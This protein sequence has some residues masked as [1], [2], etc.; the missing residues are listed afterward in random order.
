MDNEIKNSLQ[1]IKFN[2]YK[3]DLPL[4]NI[5]SSGK[6]V[7]F[8][9]TNLF[10]QMMVDLFNSSPTH[11]SIIKRMTQL[12]A[13][14]GIVYGEN[15]KL[16]KWIQDAFGNVNDWIENVGQDFLIHNAIG[17]QVIWSND[18]KWISKVKHLDASKIRVSHNDENIWISRD[19]L[20]YN[21]KI[22]KPIEMVRFDKSKSKES[23]VQILY[24]FKKN[25]GN[26]WYPIPAYYGSVNYIAL[27]KSLAEY[28]NNFVGNGF[29]A[30]YVVTAYGKNLTPDE[31][32]QMQRDIE[33][34]LIG[35][36]TAGKFILQTAPDKE[37]KWD[38]D[39]LTTADN[40]KM[41]ETLQKW[42][43]QQIM[44]AHGV[45]VPELIGASSGGVDL[46]GDANKLAA[47]YELL[48]NTQIKPVQNRIINQIIELARASGILCS[49][50]DIFISSSIPVRAIDMQV[51]TV[52][53]RRKLAGYEPIEGQDIILSSVRFDN[54]QKMASQVDYGCLMLD[55]EVEAWDEIKMMVDPEDIYQGELEYGGLQQTPHI[56]VMYG[57]HENV[58]PGEVMSATE[59]NPEDIEFNLI[60]LNRFESDLY[61]VLK[62]QVS[63]PELTELNTKMSSTFDN[64][65]THEGYNAHVTLAY[66]KK[67]LGEK[68]DKVFQDG[69]QASGKNFTFKYKQG[70]KQLN[71]K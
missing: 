43:Q 38:F 4:F 26:D 34:K 14:D 57:F 33:K 60:E 56:T 3:I 35:P 48:Q 12:I 55:L 19:W 31:N 29:S 39:A 22:S 21:Y 13:G 15:V 2:D 68:Y 70:T 1:V 23:P 41:Y 67:G 8:G 28:Y 59:I 17:S 61:D 62:F 66:I 71:W 63:V 51:L 11:S 20:Q 37:S 64:T 44:G 36:K 45:T 32:R 42:S 46:G 50:A 69:F 18:G 40:T 52:N 53:E 30:S 5:H 24:S 65:Q 25:P 9:K 54:K 7:D 49:N 58:R 16:N 47:A 27:D 10:P 6:W